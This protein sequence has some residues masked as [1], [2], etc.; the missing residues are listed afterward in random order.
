MDEKMKTTLLAVFCVLII[1]ASFV[2]M[3]YLRSTY[4]QQT[5]ELGDISF[6]A[7]SGYSYVDG[8]HEEVIDDSNNETILYNKIILQN[9]DRIIEFRQYNSTLQLNGNDV[10]DLNGMSVYRNSTDFNNQYYYFNFNGKG[11]T[12]I[13]PSGSDQLIND[14]VNSMKVKQ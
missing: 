13:T 12:I 14:I 5:I 3:Q 8:S 11:Y 2:G 9:Q 6:K 7:P 4:S 10:I 1:A